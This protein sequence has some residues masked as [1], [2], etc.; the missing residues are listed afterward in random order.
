MVNGLSRPILTSSFL[1]IGLAIILVL[2]PMGQGETV[3]GLQE[4]PLL[5]PDKVTIHPIAPGPQDNVTVIILLYLP[6][7]IYVEDSMEMNGST[8]KIA[9]RMS[10]MGGIHP[11]MNIPWSLEIPLGNLSHGEYFIFIRS[12]FS[13][14]G[15]FF[16]YNYYQSFHVADQ[17]VDPL[18]THGHQHIQDALL[19]ATDGDILRVFSGDYYENLTFNKSVSLIGNGTES[20]TIHAQE[21]TLNSSE[22]TFSDITI[23]I[24]NTDEGGEGR[25][26]DLEFP[27]PVILKYLLTFLFLMFLCVWITIRIETP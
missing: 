17:Y 1:F 8:I 21:L 20:T 27:D 11:S 13:S 26:F 25:E 18:G 23:L 14:S 24:E 6:G 10:D 3:T 22:I 12:T 16:Y 4:N 15:G 7:G 19:N 2:I 5:G 9:L